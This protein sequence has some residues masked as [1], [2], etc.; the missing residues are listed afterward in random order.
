MIG[1]NVYHRM[2]MLR[3]IGA[4]QREIA[5][6]LH[7][8]KTTVNKYLSQSE[9]AGEID[10]CRRAGRSQFSVAG[11]YIST[12][13]LQK[14]KLR[15]SR[16]YQE[17]ISRYPEITGKER[18]FRNFI[19]KIKADLPKGN[20]RIF[21]VIETDPGRQIQV[22]MGEDRIDLISGKRVKIY[23]AA[24]VLS[25][26]RQLFVHS[27]LHPYK[28]DDFIE[29]HRQAFRFF[30][31]VAEEYVYDQ[32]KLV[33]L[34][35]KYR[36]VIFNERFHQFALKAGFRPVVCEG[37]DPQSK[38]K[39]ERCIQEVHRGF[40][41]GRDFA[42]L[43][44]VRM[45][46]IMWLEKFNGRQH[47]VTHQVP[48]K[49]WDE[50]KL[51]LKKI[52]ECFIERQ[53]RKADK[54][55]LISFKGNKYSVPMVFQDRSVFVS[56]NEEMLMIHDPASAKVIATHHIPL[57]KGLM[58]KQSI[59]YRDISIEVKELKSR[60]S[61]GLERFPDGHLVVN[62]LVRENPHIVRDQLNA[63]R[64]MLDSFDDSIWK[65]SI[66][67]ILRV[68]HIKATLIEKVLQT[69][70]HQDT[71]N[72]AIADVDSAPGKESPIQRSLNDYMEVLH[73]D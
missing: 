17:V 34:H 42:D 28:T 16:L 36:E 24:F 43:P 25:F 60:I 54:T 38:G 57:G 70:L 33:A 55:G 69:K 10:S 66:P 64:K 67:T 2:L 73:H 53:T 52:P 14:P 18:A 72:N 21:S 35:E 27:Q 20:R 19:K 4:S 63:V 13:L 6:E 26:S 58:I 37:Y 39:V 8:S 3:S 30:E 71:F 32:T 29:A 1:A 40:F 12:R 7:I 61:A 49:M 45:Q 59:H 62:R 56:E 41:Y 44:D 15:T 48:Q 65:A 23:F 68:P 22:D 50:E 51:L 5:R 31:G 9:V 11:D 47:A 46:M